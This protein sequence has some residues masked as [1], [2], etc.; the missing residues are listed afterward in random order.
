[1]RD[2]NVNVNAH[3]GYAD[4][5]FFTGIGILAVDNY[6]TV[7]NAFTSGENTCLMCT[8]KWNTSPGGCRHAPRRRAFSARSE[9]QD[10]SKNG[11]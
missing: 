7:V 5:A 6:G 9:D 3:T 8:G 1:V 11:H 2:V 10:C 4:T